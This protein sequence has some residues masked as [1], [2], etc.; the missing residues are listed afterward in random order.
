MNSIDIWGTSS[1]RMHLI[2]SNAVAPL[3]SSIPPDGLTFSARMDGSVMPSAEMVFSEFGEKMRFP[4]YFG[5]NW[6]ALSD[7]IRDLHW[8]AVDRFLVVIEHVDSLLMNDADGLASLLSILVRASAEWANP[9][10]KVGGQGVPFNVV[11]SGD[12]QDPKQINPAFVDACR[13]S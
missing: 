10:G 5:W 1:P 4:S 8:L 13:Q 11:L 9:L 2:S 3:L 7:C 12:W 6:A